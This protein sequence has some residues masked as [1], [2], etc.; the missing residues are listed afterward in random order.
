MQATVVSI[1]FENSSKEYQYL[2]DSNAQNVKIGTQYRI[3][4]GVSK[5]GTIFSVI[6]VKSIKTVDVLPTVVTS[7]I[8]LN[9]SNYMANTY[10]LASERLKE[11]RTPEPSQQQ[12]VIP[13]PQPTVTVVKPITQKVKLTAEGEMT[14]HNY[15]KKYC[16]YYKKAVL[17]PYGLRYLFQYRKLIKARNTL[18]TFLKKHGMN[19]V[20]L[21]EYGETQLSQLVETK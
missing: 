20:I 15:I 6:T 9:S 19:S 18:V 5:Y 13:T 1:C 17:A 16:Y 12:K 3:P 11:L 2:L 10:R 4:K 21:N 8:K 7:G 14:L